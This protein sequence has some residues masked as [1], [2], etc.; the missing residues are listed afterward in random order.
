MLNIFFI[1]NSVSKLNCFDS[2]QI[3]SLLASPV[4]RK[5]LQQSSNQADTQHECCLYTVLFEFI[6]EVSKCGTIWHSVWEMLIAWREKTSNMLVNVC[7]QKK[8][9]NIMKYATGEWCLHGSVNKYINGIH[10]NKQKP[11][12][13]IKFVIIQ[14]Y[15]GI[16]WRKSKP[17]M[18]PAAILSEECHINS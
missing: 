2:M 13:S 6:V 5:E 12:R 16:S 10:R 4:T 1:T 15:M 14:T 9:L 7:V 11:Y 17:C 3:C 18:I 8:C